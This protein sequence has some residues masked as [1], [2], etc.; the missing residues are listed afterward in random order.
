MNMASTG[1][2]IGSKLGPIGAAVGGVLGGIAGGIFGNKAKREAMRQIRI[3]ETTTNTINA[4]R[5]T[6]TESKAMQMLA[7]R[8]YGNQGRQSLF[9]AAKGKESDVNPR[10]GLTKGT[11]LI[12]TAY[13]MRK[14]KGNSY[15]EK[16]ELIISGEEDG[17]GMHQ[18]HRVKR[19]PNDSALSYLDKNDTVANNRF[20]YPGTNK[21]VAQVAAERAAANGGKL[22]TED[23]EDIEMNQKI[24][25]SLLYLKRYKNGLPANALG[26]EPYHIAPMVQ[27]YLN[28]KFTDRWYD[29]ADE[30]GNSWFNN[31]GTTATTPAKAPVVPSNGVSGIA[32][33]ITPTDNK[34]SLFG[35]LKN[36]IGRL[37][38]IKFNNLDNI[39]PTVSGLMMAGQQYR[40]ASGP[41]RAPKLDTSNQYE[42]AALSKLGQI[43][44]YYYPVWSQNRELEGRGKNA[45]LQSGG[46]GAGQ[47]AL[48]FMG[49]TNQTQQNNANALFDTQKANNAYDSQW[50]NAALQAGAQ[51]ASRKMAAKQWDEEML[52]KA[53]AAQLQGK[54]MAMYNFQNALEQYFANKFKK[55]TFDKTKSLYE[56]DK[57]IDRDAILNLGKKYG[58]KMPR[59]N[60]KGGLS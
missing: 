14:G 38:G 42:D 44:Q 23:K 48:A 3:A 29:T 40:D 39:I 34:P 58:I 45:I 25:R 30:I 4:D 49:L 16:G 53:H 50:A 35:N 59:K 46:L 26:E 12:D 15:T 51:T 31:G 20:N 54:Q 17:N 28:P 27:H 21:T 57:D 32:G 18:T 60:K 33:T 8:E 24:G 55:Y 11:H 19:G 7:D 22:S 37:N 43:R 56:D 52:A 5:L 2:Q 9:H 47:R 1:A 6:D 10:T 36:A 13:G 41:L